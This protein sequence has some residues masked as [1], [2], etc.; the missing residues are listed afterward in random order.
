MLFSTSNLSRAC[1]LIKIELY[2]LFIAQNNY[3]YLINTVLLMSA[4]LKSKL[5]EKEHGHPQNATQK[6]LYKMEQIILR[7]NL[8]T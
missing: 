5:V 3:Y 1:H 7:L 4:T 6:L 8:H 2:I